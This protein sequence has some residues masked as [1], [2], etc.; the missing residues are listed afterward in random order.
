MNETKTIDFKEALVALVDERRTQG[1]AHPDAAEL[2]R[3][4][5]R[6]LAEDDA[7]RVREHLLTCRECLEQV[8]NPAVFTQPPSEFERAAFWRALRPE[9]PPGATPAPA[10]PRP[11]R[12]L[13]ALAAGLGGV[14]LSLGLLSLEQ[15]RTIS[16]QREVLAAQQGPIANAPIFDLTAGTKRSG[17]PAPPPLALPAGQGFTL[18][19]TPEERVSAGRFELVVARAGGEVLRTIPDLHPHPEDGTFTLWL[20]AGTLPEGELTLELR[21]L[22]GTASRPVEAFR[23]VVGGD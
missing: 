8:R 4:R 11:S 17:G 9:L 5:A 23:V 10:R 12:T 6:E 16:R 1:E 7:E 21:A 13:Y 20:P 14:A 19:L 15:G 18:V 2:A 22:G 3:F